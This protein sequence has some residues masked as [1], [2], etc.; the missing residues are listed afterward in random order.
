MS[1]VAKPLLIFDLDETLIHASEA[2]LTRQADYTFDLYFIYERPYLREMLID[3]SR[4]FILSVWSSAGDDYV[5][6]LADKIKP[7]EVDFAFAW[8]NSRCTLRFD[9]ESASYFNL[10]NL[11]KV[12]RKGFSLRRTLIVDNTPAK[13]SANYGNAIYIPDFTGDPEDQELLRLRDY[14]LLIKDKEDFTRIEKRSWK[15][16]V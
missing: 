4:H 10:K 6:F 16:K 15:N 7:S 8:G 3:L 5:A 2:E 13:V 11:K 14:L 1:D 9:P 12:K